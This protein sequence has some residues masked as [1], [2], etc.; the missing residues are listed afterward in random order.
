MFRTET[1]VRPDALLGEPPIEAGRPHSAP[2]ST[3]RAQETPATIHVLVVEDDVDQAELVQRTL[4]RQSFRVT[5]V[6]DSAACFQAVAGDRYSIILL[7]YSLPRMN[8]L[9]VLTAL[10][11]RGVCAPV[12]MITAQGDE[13]LAI[14]SM[15]AGGMDFV[16][17]TSG[18]LAALSTVLRKVLTQH[19]LALENERLHRETR[20]R[21]RDAEALVD[22]SRTITAN[23]DLEV[24]LGVIGQAA[25]RACDM[26]RCSIFECRNGRA[27]LLVSQR[28]GGALDAELAASFRDERARPVAELPFL[29]AAFARGDA[30]VIEDASR[31]PRVPADLGF[32]ANTVLVLPLARQATAT[33]ALVLDTAAGDGPVAAARVVLATTVAGHVGLALDNA[34]LYEETQRTLAH[35][36]EAQ[37]RLVRGETLRALGELASGAAHHLNNLLAVIVGRSQLLLRSGKAPDARRPL[38]IIERSALDGAEVVRRIQQFSRTRE[39]D[40]AQHVDLNQVASDVVEMT[41]VRWHDGAVAQGIAITDLVRAGRDPVRPRESG[42]PAGGR[43][44]SPPERDRRAPAWRRHPRPHLGRDRAGVSRA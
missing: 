41:R 25:A 27:R 28:A 3:A 33:G 38:E 10:R 12:V 34:R 24:L 44:Q 22:L 11:A 13:R 35:L 8:G 18:Y 40:D 2:T 29:A 1:G 7:D 36:E 20:Q 39:A 43:H 42:L 6:G 26:D 4:E 14:E 23:L 15:Q 17:K 16:V 30:V 21:L 5:V 32:R 19:D 31:D 37:D 9:E